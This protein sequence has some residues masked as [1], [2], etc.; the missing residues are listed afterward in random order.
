MAPIGLR[1]FA[2]TEEGVARVRVGRG[3]VEAEIVLEGLHPQCVA[4]DPNDPQRVFAGTLDDGL[5]HSLDGGTTWARAGTLGAARVMSV[6]VSPCDVVDALS[7]VYAGTEPSNLYRSEDDGRTWEALVALRDVP[8]APSWSFP[9]RPWTSHVRA[10]ALH[11]RDPGILFAGI[12]LGGVMRSLDR[13]ATWEDRKSGSYPD[14]H[15]LATHPLA[16]DR[17]YEAAG[18]GVAL[19]DDR[20][21][22][23]RTVDDGMDLH[24]VWSLA[25]DRSDPDLWYVSAAPGPMQAHG[26]RRAGAALYRRRGGAPW[27]RLDGDGAMGRDLEVMPYALVAASERPGIVI[28]AMRNGEIA[29]TEDAGDSWRVLEGRLPRIVAA[30]A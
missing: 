12:E 2:A 26:D 24:Y 16:L 7:V 23:W 8:S 27:Q 13:G 6:A 29:V 10:I 22:T 14:S 30:T 28:A 11:H 9:P 5:L 17:V 18:G 1:L 21:E 4:V 20:G 25:V 19:S 15:A 3:R